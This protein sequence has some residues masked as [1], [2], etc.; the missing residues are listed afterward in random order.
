MAIGRRV[1]EEA[2]CQGCTT[3]NQQRPYEV[4]IIQHWGLLSGTPPDAR[5]PQAG[6]S[7]ASAH[8]PGFPPR[9]PLTGL[10]PGA[11]EQPGCS[12]WA[13]KLG[14]GQPPRA[15]SPTFSWQEG[16]VGGEHFLLCTDSRGDVIA[17]SSFLTAAPGPKVSCGQGGSAQ[18]GARAQAPNAALRA[19]GSAVPQEATWRP[20]LHSGSLLQDSPPPSKKRLAFSEAED[21]FS[22]PSLIAICLPGIFY[23][24]KSCLPSP[25]LPSSPTF[26]LQNR[27]LKHLSHG[28]GKKA[29]FHAAHLQWSQRQ[30]GNAMFSL[31]WHKL[32]PTEAFSVPNSF[33]KCLLRSIRSCSY[34]RY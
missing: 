12:A 21:A 3:E 13:P 33:L 32:S 27:F 17:V 24:F 5:G 1:K 29:Y 11:L 16:G 28:R 31:I 20:A 26:Y 4:S 34:P 18:P 15:A 19:P 6:R 7:A 14:L 23:S 25:I 2:S 22:L 30:T 8:P 9:Q 10:A